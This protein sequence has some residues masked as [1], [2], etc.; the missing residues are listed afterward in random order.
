MVKYLLASKI[1]GK[2]GECG[3]KE[4]ST[5]FETYGPEVEG[6]LDLSNESTWAH[7]LTDFNKANDKIL[8]RDY[9]C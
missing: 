9:H 8:E 4:T 5:L 3:S 6:D 2:H 1:I 7:Y